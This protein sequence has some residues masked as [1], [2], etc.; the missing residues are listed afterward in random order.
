M[1]KKIIS[2]L[3]VLTFLSVSSLSS[4]FA[5]GSYDLKSNELKAKNLNEKIVKIIADNTIV[6]EKGLKIKDEKILLNN[7]KE[8]DLLPLKN[9][10][11]AKGG[12]FNGTT[13]EKIIIEK[14]KN[15]METIN[16]GISKG[17]LKILKKV[18]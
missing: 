7:I 12:N 1:F 5:M 18:Q 15:G 13:I 3:L 14:T 17:K 10:I 4:V 6:S 16:D 8:L 9:F 2:F 11:E